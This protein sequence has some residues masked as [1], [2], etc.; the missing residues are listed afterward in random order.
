MKNVLEKQAAVT[1]NRRFGLVSWCAGMNFQYTLPKEVDGI[2]S[3]YAVH[4]ATT[5]GKPDFDK[6]L[7]GA[8]CY[9]LEDKRD[10]PEIK[11]R[12]AEHKRIFAPI[13][14]MEYWVCSEI[15]GSDQVRK[16]A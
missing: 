2:F 1:N 11:R 15:D 7:K 9:L 14:K 5:N 12:I 13:R 8:L 6:P 10:L 3:V 16:V 4:F